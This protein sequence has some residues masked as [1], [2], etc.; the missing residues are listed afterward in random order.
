M[1]V[2]V[3]NVHVTMGGW[4]PLIGSSWGHQHSWVEDGLIC[5]MHRHGIR[6]AVSERGVS[7]RGQHMLPGVLEVGAHPI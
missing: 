7:G 5:R 2:R 1:R 4:H 6:G 3:G